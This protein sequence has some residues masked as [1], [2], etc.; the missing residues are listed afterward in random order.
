MS[1]NEEKTEF[2]VDRE[3]IYAEIKKGLNS[4]RPKEGDALQGDA[5]EKQEL[6]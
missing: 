6:R 2:P 3:V 1:E 5:D 4:L